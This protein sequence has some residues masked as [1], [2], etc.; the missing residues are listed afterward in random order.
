MYY[1]GYGSNLKDEQM[2]SRVP[3]ARFVCMTTMPDKQVVFR[4]TEE[5]GYYADMID[6]AGSRAVVAVYEFSDDDFDLM[7]KFEHVDDGFYY[8]D[9]CACILSSGETVEGVFYKMAE[10]KG[11]TVGPPRDE[12]VGRI[13]YGFVNK[14]VDLKE[15]TSILQYNRMELL[16]SK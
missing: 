5:W 10:D 1:I 12:Y 6:M 11:F 9:T 4:G 14:G 16:L 8:R 15:L 3:G 13:A 7:D 2:K